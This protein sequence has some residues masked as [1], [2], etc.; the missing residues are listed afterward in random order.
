MMLPFVPEVKD[1][2]DWNADVSSNGTLPVNFVARK[3]SVVLT[4]HDDDAEKQCQEYAEWEAGG[5]IDKFIEALALCDECTAEAI[6]ADGN[7]EPYNKAR[8]AGKIEQ[9]GICGAFS[10]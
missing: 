3:G 5:A 8:H 2:D 4:K 10:D 7:A 1:E 9:P 6:V